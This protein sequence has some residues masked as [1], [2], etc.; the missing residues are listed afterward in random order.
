MS[1]MF[2][3]AFCAAVM[4]SACGSKSSG[5]KNDAGAS[6]ATSLASLPATVEG[7]LDM[8]AGEGDEDDGGHEVLFGMLTVDGA[9]IFSVSGIPCWI[10]AAR[11]KTL[12]VEPGWKPAESPYFCGTV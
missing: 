1:R 7:T 9:E 2:V 8:S 11:T 10:A 4:L 3:F 6:P 5:S 12:N